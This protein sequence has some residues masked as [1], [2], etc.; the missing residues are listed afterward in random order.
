[1]LS[2]KF[3]VKGA[4]L[5]QQTCEQRRATIEP[6]RRE[7][8]VVN[9]LEKRPSKRPV[10]PPET[11][12]QQD[13][14]DRALQDVLAACLWRAYRALAGVL[15]ETDELRTPKFICFLFR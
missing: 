14:G 3:G 11:L 7:H 4:R 10:G 2:V 9:E 13:V 12:S 6:A 1:M 5:S 15:C 8:E